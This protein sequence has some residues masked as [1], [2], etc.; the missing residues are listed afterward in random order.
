MARS[1]RPFSLPRGD[2]D[3]LGQEAV[4]A[5]EVEVAG[6][7]ADGLAAA[8]QH[9]ALQVVAPDLA[10]HAPPGLE[11]VGM[12][13]Q[14]VVHRRV[15]VEA[16]ED[17]ARVAEHHHE[18]H[19]PALGAA[20]PDR[21]EVGPVDLGLLAG[22]RPEPHIGLGR[23]LR[24]HR[25][26]HLAEV[27]L[28][29][30]LVAAPAHH[31]V[32]PAG[33]QLRIVLQGL[34]D[35][36]DEGIDLRTPPPPRR[37]RPGVLDHPPD[38]AVMDAELARDRADLPLLG[39]IQPQDLR[40]RLLVQGHLIPPM[41][42]AAP[43]AAPD[44]P[45]GRRTARSGRSGTPGP[46]GPARRDA[47]PSAPPAAPPQQGA[48]RPRSKGDASLSARGPESP[49]PGNGGARGSAAGARHACD[50]RAGCPGSAARQ[51]AAHHAAPARRS[52]WSN[53]CCRGRSA[54]R[55]PPGGGTRRS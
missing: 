24:P 41:P 13:A 25:G 26:D 43:G 6:I 15:Q 34:L 44:G 35:E 45:L 51:D 55:E 47:W 2:R 31:L 40:A 53:R 42:G 32:E 12:A 3:G 4:V 20:D 17:A 21:A 46:D 38:G 18:A 39:V 1:T 49:R 33:R 30:A 7:E 37:R 10:G 48:A 22:K 16:Q 52:P 54:G 5:G 11:G 8:F 9:G 50:G 27:A 28:A 19:Q 23:G 36:R 29:P 14:E